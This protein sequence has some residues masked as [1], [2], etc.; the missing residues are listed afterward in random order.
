MKYVVDDC[1]YFDTAE[2]AAEYLANYETSSEDDF[3][4]FLDE[5]FGDCK[6]AGYEYSTSYALKEVDETA[7]RCEFNDWQSQRFDELKEEYENIIEGMDVGDT[8]SIENHWIDLV[9]DQKE[10]TEDEE[11]E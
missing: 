6:I 4:H 5:V 1:E 10:E 7:Y 2:E 3:D 11:E 8:E 9:E